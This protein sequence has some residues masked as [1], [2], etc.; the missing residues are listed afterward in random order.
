MCL[1]ETTTLQTLKLLKVPVC[2][3][4][5]I[6]LRHCDVKHPFYMSIELQLRKLEFN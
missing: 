1:N 3:V 6:V 5:V 4:V 2:F